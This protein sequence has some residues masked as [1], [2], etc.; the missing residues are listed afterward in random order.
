VQ[1]QACGS[2]TSNFLTAS[3][4]SMKTIEGAS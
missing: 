3:I 4:S 1:V 2:E